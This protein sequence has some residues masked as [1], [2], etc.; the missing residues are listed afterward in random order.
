MDLSEK[1]SVF[2]CDTKWNHAAEWAEVSRLF[3]MW[4]QSIHLYVRADDLRYL[5]YAS[6]SDVAYRQQMEA[7]HRARYYA[8]YDAF[9]QHANTN[10]LQIQT[11]ERDSTGRILQ[12]FTERVY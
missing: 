11:V 7:T 9:Y 5:G 1:Y 3:R 2:L 8:A 12:N 10:N 4:Q 6:S